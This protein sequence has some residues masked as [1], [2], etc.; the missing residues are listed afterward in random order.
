MGVFS[1][2]V[3]ETRVKT[4]HARRQGYAVKFKQAG[5]TRILTMDG[6]GLGGEF[7][8]DERESWGW[9]YVAC[10]AG[11]NSGDSPLVASKSTIWGEIFSSLYSRR[12]TRTPTRMYKKQGG[13]W[14]FLFFTWI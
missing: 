5:H 4:L 7:V 11:G 2:A 10:D 6:G 3:Y 9:R 8:C 14:S 1:G 13:V 12:S